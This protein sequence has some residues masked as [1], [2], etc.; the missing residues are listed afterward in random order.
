MNRRKLIIGAAVTV[1]TAASAATAQACNYI[2][3]DDA[4]F[5]YAA[6]DGW[7]VWVGE[8]AEIEPEGSYGVP[9]EFQLGVF[10]WVRVRL[11]R[12]LAGTGEPSVRARYGS[13]GL[14]CGYPWEPRLGEQ[15]IVVGHPQL[16][17]VVTAEQGRE[18]RYA[19][20]FTDER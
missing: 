6:A 2:R 3:Q 11:V 10:G 4:L 13:G 8:V 16:P 9:N 12:S 7:P 5:D 15:V 17:V 1:A 14:Y 19:A 20:I 18:T